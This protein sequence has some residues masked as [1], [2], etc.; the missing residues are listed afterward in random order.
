M[1][2]EESYF[3]PVEYSDNYDLSDTGMETAPSPKKRRSDSMSMKGVSRINS[4][5]ST[6]SARWKTKRSSGGEVDMFPDDLRSRA[7]SAASSA[8]ASPITS[9][10]T[11]SRVDSIPPSPART[12]FEERLNE[13][14]TRPI[15]I[16]RANSFSQDD[17]EDNQATTPLLP[18]F[19]GDDPT[20]VV[21]SRVQSPLQSPSVAD[22]NESH[23]NY[24]VT[25][26]PRFTGILPSPPLSSKPSIAS[27]NRPRAS[28]VR[29]VSADA[30]PFVLSDP[31]DEWANKLGHA[32]FTISPEPY[33][34]VCCDMASFQTMRA[35]WDAARCNF[36]KHLVRTGE[37]Y[38]ATST[39]YK[40]TVEKWE[41]IN[42][43]WT[44]QYEAML[45]QLGDD[46]V[47]LTLTQSNIHPCQVRVPALH[48]DKFPEMGD[49]DIVG[50]MTVAGCRVKSEKKRNFFRF[51]QDLVSRP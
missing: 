7:N 6:M 5:I 12:I 2:A 45:N 49:E 28:T 43:D 42:S 46:A 48:E 23:C 41:A 13:S 39:I 44:A 20:S 16:T 27:F 50:P 24:N 38:G 19:M 22:V 32:N 8:L 15:D 9:P 17:N 29:A 18:P 14:G 36:A 35:D 11:M 25:S 21:A 26:E 37:H 3:A 31:N 4:H 51:F 33:A 47:A 10:M 40:L 1:C 34:P 30:T